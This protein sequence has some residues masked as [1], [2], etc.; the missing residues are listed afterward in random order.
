MSMRFMHLSYSLT[1]IIFVAADKVAR[2]K[3]HMK[4]F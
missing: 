3:K 2:K 4:E 1:K